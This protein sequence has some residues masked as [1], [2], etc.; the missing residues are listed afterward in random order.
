MARCSGGANAC[1]C[2]IHA[3]Q[4]IAAPGN[5]SLADPTTISV[6]ASRDAANCVRFGSDGGLFVPCREGE[7]QDTCGISVGN[8]PT[9]RLVFGRGGAGRLLA[10]DHTL[11]SFRRAVELGLDG[12]HALVREL[13][14]GTPVCYPSETMTN[15]TGI[16]GITLAGM[17]VGGYKN[18]PIRTG[19]NPSSTLNLGG[20]HGFFG[21]GE[22]D[23]VGGVTLAEVLDTVGRRAVLN[24]E[25]IPPYSEAFPHKV[26]SHIYRY[27]AQEAIIVSSRII[28]DL[29]PFVTA[30]IPTWLV[31]PDAASADENPPS[32]L[33]DRGV[34]W[35]SGRVGLVTTDQFVAYATAG[36]HTIG[37]MCNRHYDW[38]YLDEIGARGCLSDDALYMTADPDRYRSKTMAEPLDYPQVQPGVMGYWT[39]QRINLPSGPGVPGEVYWPNQGRGFYFPIEYSSS[40]SFY[41]PLRGAT[42]QDEPDGTPYRTPSGIFDVSMGFVNPIP[43]PDDYTLEIDMSYRDTPSQNRTAG[44]LLGLPD[45]RAHED[46]ANAGDP[47]WIAGLSWTGAVYVERWENGSIIANHRQQGPQLAEDVFYRVRLTVTPESVT[48]SKLTASGQVQVSATVTDSSLR[49]PYTSWYKKET[50]ADGSWSPFAVAWRNLEIYSNSDP[51]ERVS[52]TAPL[53]SEKPPVQDVPGRPGMGPGDSAV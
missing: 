6:R 45:D 49:G 33:L 4:G 5:G 27:C 39:D 23:R 35:M 38:E 37:Y 40:R 12:S 53:P 25:L 11:T 24:L 34:E 14:D 22:R 28:D 16:P 21:F 19:W 51:G 15:Q 17:G 2:I 18:V 50:N 48:F 9:E 41:M 10:P 47:F 36:I 3:G 42:A 29:E 32:L 52:M 8:L 43:W 30:N 7:S 13:G 46:R 1:N 44:L 20:R 31:V 26:L